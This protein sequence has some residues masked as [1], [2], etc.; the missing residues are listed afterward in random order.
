[1]HWAGHSGRES[2]KALL[3]QH[4][5]WLNIDKDIEVYVKSCYV[6]QMNKPERTKEAGS[7]SLSLSPR[8]H[9][10]LFQWTLFLVF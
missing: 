6:C 7:W 8:G 3:S 2:M 4:Y 1:M 10:C 9:G 5:Y